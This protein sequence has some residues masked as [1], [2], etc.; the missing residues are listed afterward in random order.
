[1]TLHALKDRLDTE[2]PQI[3]ERLGAPGTAI[4]V[5]SGTD[6]FSTGYGVTNVLHPLPITGDTIFQVG[7]ISKTFVGIIAAQLEKEGRL[8]IN[9]P[10]APLLRDLGNVD[11]R[12]TMRHLLTHSSG[13][14][15]QYMIGDARQIL[16]N[17][18]DDSI[19]ASIK[20]FANDPLLFEPGTDFSY[21][22]P[23]FMVAGAVIER[24][25]N[26]RWADILRERVLRPAGMEQTFTT[27]DEVM[28][29]RVAAP[30]DVDDDG[31][32]YLARNQGWQ[33]GWQLPGWDVPGGGVLS[34]VNELMKYA[35][36]AWSANQEQGFF[37]TL[38]NR[39]VPG[40]DIGYAWK[41]E[42]RRGRTVMGHNGLTIGYSSRFYTVPE[43][44]LA[45]AILT[46]SL[47]GAAVNNA[48]ERII[49][50]E[51]YGQAE[52]QDSPTTQLSE[53]LAGVYD[54][55]FYGQVELAV[56]PDG[57]SY[58]LRSLQ[59]PHDAG[60]F[61]IEPPFIECLVPVGDGLLSSDPGAEIPEATVPYI[62]DE[63][64]RVTALRIAERISKRIK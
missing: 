12:I 17:H 64:G 21:S 33:L 23:G 45:Y 4:A 22:G 43:E 49:L 30:H 5:R 19:Q 51:L 32:P 24:T 2:I 38:M 6:A 53:G 46:N 50:D 25:L 63:N 58:T 44:N 41:Q 61:I 15:A 29:Y 62:R 34:S 54:S 59:T 35:E 31:S 37:A 8:D 60:G 40:H 18:A 20:H 13:I 1:M 26:A 55:G 39:G 47:Q 10:V 14:D 57:N 36:Y 3:L 28:T 7:S 48:V 11:H 16:S 56:R 27:A 42:Q 52:V 9:A